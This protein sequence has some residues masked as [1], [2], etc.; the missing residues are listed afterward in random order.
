MYMNS[1]SKTTELSLNYHF[2]Q[3]INK[4]RI[5]YKSTVVQ[6]KTKSHVKRNFPTNKS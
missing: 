2:H 3:H 1:E 6:I 4:N 5:N